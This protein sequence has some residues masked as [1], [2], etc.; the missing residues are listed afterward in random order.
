MDNLDS[1]L[2]RTFLAVAEAGSV[3]GGAARVFRSQSAA[4]LQLKQLETILQRRVFERHGRGISLTDAGRAL[5]PVAREVTAR[6]D[7][8][9]EEINADGLRGTL[10]VGIPD[11]HGSTKLA[12]IVG[13]FARSHPQVD[14]EIVCSISA[15]F[16]DAVSK[17]LLDI[18][19]YEVEQPAENETVLHEEP[20]CWAASPYRDFSRI[21]PLPVA[22]FDR[23]CWWRDAALESLKSRQTPHRIVYSSQSVAGVRA[24]VEAGVAVGL[25]GHASATDGLTILGKD[26]GFGDTPPSKLVLGS[27]RHATSKAADTMR[28]VIQSAFHP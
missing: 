14:L 23:A 13:T 2:L 15:E 11:D 17:G 1:S 24:A 27:N 7:Q 4:S 16:P 19:V 22:L 12:Q 8:A 21:T 26:H 5:L 10:R 18:A 25:L 9:L 6:L 20:T 28:Q 3:T